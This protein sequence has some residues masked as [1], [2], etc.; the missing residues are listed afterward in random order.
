MGEELETIDQREIPLKAG[1]RGRD[2]N[3]LNLL[4]AANPGDYMQ[5]NED[6]LRASNGTGNNSGHKGTPSNL[7]DLFDPPTQ[8]TALSPKS[9]PSPATINIPPGANELPP[10]GPPR[11][12]ALHKR[13]HS[14]SFDKDALMHKPASDSVVQQP[15]LMEA[16]DQAS[17]ASR[18]SQRPSLLS[19][20]S[21]ISVNLGALAR[22]QQN[23]R[24]VTIEDLLGTG[25]Y[26]SEAETNI[27]KALEEHQQQNAPAHQR[28]Q[29]ETSTI[30]S[31]VPDS[32]AHDF[33]TEPSK[34]IDSTIRRD[35]SQDE[36]DSSPSSMNKLQSRPLL[37]R[38]K[39][40]KAGKHRHTMSVED[41]L[42]GLTIA[43][44][45]ME[46]SDKDISGESSPD[47]ASSPPTSSGEQFGKNAAMVAGHDTP[48]RGRLNSQGSAFAL[49]VV[50][51]TE[52]AHSSDDARESG[53]GDIEEPGSSGSGSKHS[54]GQHGRKGRRNRRR[55]S[56]ISGAA[57]RL[58]EDWDIWKTFFRPRREHMVSYIKRFFCY[59][60][61]PFIGIAA[62][63]FYLAGN[64]P[65]GR[66]S[67]GSPGTKASPS[68]W[69]L[70]VVR[71]FVTMSI[72][73]FL[74]VVIIDFLCIGTK[75]MLR[76]LGPL[77]TLLIVQSKGWPF[78]VFCW[79]ILDFGLLYGNNKFVQH[80]AYFQELVGLFNSE[81]P[82]GGIVGSEWNRRILLIGVSVS[83][84][85]SL[86][87]FVVGLILG[88][89]T[90]RKSTKGY[91]ESKCVNHILTLG[92]AQITMVNNSQRS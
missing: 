17:V 41:R 71:Q 67:D 91:L 61:V 1:E 59:L 85:T 42:A 6:T 75:G 69:L 10:K 12:D 89:Q 40:R 22:R 34:S 53:G 29:S 27:L 83:L 72:G 24:K 9:P 66:S 79:S 86:K 55:S 43:M 38:E 14:V 21:G 44:W 62:I 31:G 7:S 81:N 5:G 46:D 63:L 80:W 36:E 33:S 57:D 76:L 88:R 56:I 23:T 84:C 64:V 28:Y 68:W 30:L 52:E 47:H 37:N 35:S 2:Q 8:E 51:E 20:R 73:L 90:F 48:I 65:T 18:V 3:F 50:D 25:K 39:S 74:Q 60:V 16:V 19:N 58:K 82:S 77:L 11:P 49:A 32:M 92:V 13:I 4:R 15:N 87:R 45:N 78:V 54:G 26:E 70:F